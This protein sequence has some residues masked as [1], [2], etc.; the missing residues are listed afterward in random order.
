MSNKV[1]AKDVV[2]FFKDADAELGELVLEM[3]SNFVKAKSEA[4]NAAVQ[5]MAKARAGR[6]KKA[7]AAA[8]AATPAVV[9]A[10]AASSAGQ[11]DGPLGE[12]RARR[13]AA[14]TGG[15]VG[16]LTGQHV[17]APAHTASATSVESDT[18]LS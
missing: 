2:Q 13:V 5:R 11:G 7:K 14:G 10:P 9:Q 4:K 1:T 18:I 16:G 3:G 17:P 12:A 6:G 15:M 8:P